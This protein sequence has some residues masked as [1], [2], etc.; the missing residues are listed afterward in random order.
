MYE[1]ILGFI[2]SA[3]LNR[4]Y[5]IQSNTRF[6][7]RKTFIR[8]WGSNRQNLKKIVRKSRGKISKI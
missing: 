8:K 3:F 5:K 1:V 2:L 4:N 6:F 7:I